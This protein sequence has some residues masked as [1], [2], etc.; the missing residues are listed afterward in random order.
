MDR[1][2]FPPSIPGPRTSRASLNASHASHIYVLRAISVILNFKR[3]KVVEKGGNC[4]SVPWRLLLPSWQPT[5]S[6]Q[7]PE[8]IERRGRNKIGRNES[9]RQI[10]QMQ[11][12]GE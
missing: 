2:S 11:R 3:R 1:E 5:S 8:K 4:V 10:D 9:K 6:Y 7:M 12:K